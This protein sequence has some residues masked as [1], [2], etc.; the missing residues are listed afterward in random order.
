MSLH[1]AHAYLPILLQSSAPHEITLMIKFA[2]YFSRFGQ[3]VVAAEANEQSEMNRDH[4]LCKKC[5]VELQ[6]NLERTLKGSENRLQVKRFQIQK[7]KLSEQRIKLHSD[8]HS[9]S[10]LP[11]S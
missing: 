11:V 5:V 2:E 3:I 10:F 6:Y 8:K 9:E 1:L 7:A 4:Q